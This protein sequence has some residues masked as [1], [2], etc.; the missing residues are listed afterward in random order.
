MNDLIFDWPSHC[1][2]IL[3]FLKCFIFFS[4]WNL[5]S[6]SFFIFFEQIVL[7]NNWCVASGEESEEVKVQNSREARALEAVYPRFSAIPPK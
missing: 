4:I 5:S 2:F 6:H 1:S 3:S 7:S